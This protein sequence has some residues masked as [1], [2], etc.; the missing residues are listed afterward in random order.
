MHNLVSLPRHLKITML[1]CADVACLFIALLMALLLRYD[2]LAAGLRAHAAVILVSAPLLT[3]MIFALM[4]VYRNVLRFAGS[5]MTMHI[6]MVMALSTLVLIGG[7]F[8]IESSRT[9][10]P[11]VFVIYGL[12]GFIATA[13]LRILI[14]RLIQLELMKKQSRAIIYGAGEAGARLAEALRNDDTWKPI[15]F[16]DDNPKNQGMTVAD[17][18]VL[19]S[20]AIDTFADRHEVDAVF[21]AMP[22]VSRN[23]RRRILERVRHAGIKVLTVPTLRELVGGL[24]DF[25]DV[26]QLDIEDLIDR[27]MVTADENLLKNALASGCVLVTGAGGSIGSELCRQI[28]SIR[29]T[30]LVALDQSEFNLYTLEQELTKAQGVS[31]Q[32]Q[33]IPV[34]FVLG[35]V[36]DRLMLEGH[37]PHARREDDVPCSCLQACPDR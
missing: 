7:S 27:T 14:R 13:A 37:D 11:S 3:V 4:G 2:D 36:C 33:G 23:I 31:P 9:Q 20:S 34:E 22:S 26:R 24:A 17:L 18:P 32:S 6:G 5:K 29:P 8:L 1:V 12:I 19:A 21:L 15:A 28:L 30:K 16:V 10:F 35:D 25:N